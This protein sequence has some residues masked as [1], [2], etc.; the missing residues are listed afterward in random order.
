MQLSSLLKPHEITVGVLIL[1]LLKEE[2]SI[3]LELKNELTFHLID[4][5]ECEGDNLSRVVNDK[6]RNAH[7]FSSLSSFGSFLHHL[8]SELSAP[9]KT[10]LIERL[11]HVVRCHLIN[12]KSVYV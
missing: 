10:Y 7:E 3:S 5:I 2:Q 1:L 11:K 8:E 12:R 6:K 9:D 4:L